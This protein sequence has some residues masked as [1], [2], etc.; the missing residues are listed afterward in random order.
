MSTNQ[1]IRLSP[2][3]L[4]KEDYIKLIAAS[5]QRYCHIMEPKECKGMNLDPDLQKRCLEVFRDC[6]KEAEIFARWSQL[7]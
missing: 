1:S 4:S 3:H 6:V 5:P 7:N 2:P